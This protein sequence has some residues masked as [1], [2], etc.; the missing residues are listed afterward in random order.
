M[1]NGVDNRSEYI[2]QLRTLLPP[3]EFAQLNLDEL[4]DA[5]LQAKL[6]EALNNNSNWGEF[7]NF[8]RENPQESV[9]EPSSQ[10]VTVSDNGCTVSTSTNAQGEE[11]TEKKQGNELI[12]K[13]IKRT[14]TNGNVIETVIN[15][16]N[17]KIAKKTVSCNG[18][19]VE[20]ST[21]EIS[22]SPDGT[23][24][25]IINTRNLENNQTTQTK[26]L[27]LD[28]N[29]NY[30]DEAFVSRSVNDGTTITE[31][32]TMTG[33]MLLNLIN[34]YPQLNF[35]TSQITANSRYLCEKILDSDGTISTINVYNTSLVNNLDSGNANKLLQL[36]TTG[37]NVNIVKYDGNGNTIATANAGDG[38]ERITKRFF[39]ETGNNPAELARMQSKIE[40]L[41]NNRS[42]LQAGEEILIPGEFD[43]DS[44]PLL[45]TES[46]EIARQRAAAAEYNLAAARANYSSGTG[47][48][49][50]TKDYPSVEALAR[51]S[52]SEQGITNP[53]AQQINYRKNEII[54]LNQGKTSYRRGDVIVTVTS[55]L[56]PQTSQ[57]LV[58]FGF[59]QNENNFIFYQRFNQLDA[60]Q[61]EKALQVMQYCKAHNI[62]N[63]DDIK[64]EILKT[65]PDINLFDSGKT[66]TA[67]AQQN[68]QSAGIGPNPIS[69]ETFITTRLGLD[70]SSG[71]GK[72]LYE[73][74]CS[75]PQ[76]ELNKIPYA[77]FSGSGF[78]DLSF[79]DMLTAFSHYVQ[80][81]TNTENNII[82]SHRQEDPINQRHQVIGMMSRIVQQCI[83]ELQSHLDN[84]RDNMFTNLG[85]IMIEDLRSIPGSGAI[86]NLAH[87]MGL[88]SG[89]LD[90]LTQSIH[91]KINSLQELNTNLFILDDNRGSS[92][93]EQAF[94]RFVG[95]DYDPEKVEQ[96]MDLSR[97]AESG[98]SGSN[99]Q[100]LNQRLSELL[101]DI[102]GNDFK[103]NVIDYLSW[104]QGAG[105]VAEIA[106]TTV[107]TMGIGSAVG[108]VMGTATTLA[109]RA[110]ASAI[111]LG[112][113]SGIR[114]GLNFLDDIDN[115]I[116]GEKTIGGVF[117]GEQNAETMRL[118][119][120]I[121]RSFITGELSETEAQTQLNN[122]HLSFDDFMTSRGG[123]WVVN[124]TTST[125]I[126]GV[127]GAASP[128]FQRAGI[129]GTHA[130]QKFAERFPTIGNM[131][132]LNA[133]AVQEV[134]TNIIT[135]NA[136]GISGSEFMAQ[137]YAALNATNIAGKGLQFLTETMIFYMTDLPMSVIQELL[138]ESNN[139]LEEALANGTL[140]EY[141]ADKLK[142]QAVS[143]LE[144]KS[145]GSIISMMIGANTASQV[146]ER[147]DEFETLKNTTIRYEDVTT[148][149]GSGI[150]VT[151]KVITVEGASGKIFIN[152]DLV[153]YYTKQG[154][155]IASEHI[156]ANTNLNDL[157]VGSKT[158]YLL[159]LMIKLEN[160]A[161][162]R[163]TAL[164][165]V[166]Q[167]QNTALN[168]ATNR[169]VRLS[170]PEQPA[171]NINGISPHG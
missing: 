170:E 161:S 118:G 8:T 124:T 128:I 5:Q 125:I 138:S 57:D 23:N 39:S 147:F 72:I 165:P 58:R 142:E 65:H 3:S 6:N 107:A 28:I 95:N 97:Q 114:F 36:K 155:H 69:L 52:L 44:A 154:Q 135:S 134:T 153:S 53:T 50:L 20:E 137:T 29:G 89:K 141:L 30:G 42:S 104:S 14:D 79:D 116:R 99:S 48:V 45:H 129:I 164:N 84:L 43:A 47:S 106:L 60:S 92:N 64:A 169:S 62:T 88:Q 1:G 123:Q 49:T 112:S 100:E 70:I 67:Y 105:S 94:K 26:V 119:A 86:A 132:G 158:T 9:T 73:R 33:E 13:I 145:I 136:A 82:Q 121:I 59:T 166:T 117:V 12:E 38:W 139:Q 115:V 11:I 27:G 18:T 109:G 168:P 63:P 91:D 148:A 66:I 96:L 32:E 25:F 126:G 152:G 71:N 144:I 10:G 16:N 130:G 167:R 150:P 21:Y 120:Q 163:N 34:T 111:T 76:S 162:G 75:L 40:T 22:T 103:S 77:Q 146:Q 151:N 113:Y 149:D 19:A 81:R 108:G 140:D 56:S 41:N 159:G 90:A 4:T 51:E 101:M 122:L 98:A 83:R 15:Y 127:A 31:T 110:T 35:D 7:D 133:P 24:F 46:P 54:V 37:S 80:I 55:Q 143:L 61:Q 131:L 156:P 102:M 93:F 2:N 171:S 68:S 160:Y 74:L 78:A 157:D 85:E 87:T 17:G